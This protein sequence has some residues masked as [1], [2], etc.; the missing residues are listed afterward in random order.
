[1][2]TRTVTLTLTLHEVALLRQSVEEMLND[3]DTVWGGPDNHREIYEA[4]ERIDAKLQTVEQTQVY[5]H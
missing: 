5:P 4:Y 3:S 1:M 2:T